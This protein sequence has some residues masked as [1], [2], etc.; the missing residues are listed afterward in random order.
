MSGDY[1]ENES[2]AYWYNRAQKA[3]SDLKITLNEINALQSALDLLHEQLDEVRGQRL[4][5]GIL[6][7]LRADS[8]P[9]LPEEQQSESLDAD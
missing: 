2:I 1:H 3:E 7:P 4:G 5:G 9:M 6:P 8:T